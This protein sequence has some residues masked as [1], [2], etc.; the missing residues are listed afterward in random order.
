MYVW[1]SPTRWSK[2]RLYHLFDM[3]DITRF[4]RRY[5]ATFSLTSQTILVYEGYGGSPN[6]WEIPEDIHVEVH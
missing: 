4:P 1:P 3:S 2:C 5:S 6:V